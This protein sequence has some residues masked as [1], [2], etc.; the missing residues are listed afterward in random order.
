MEITILVYKARMD[1]GK[2]AYVV[3]NKN[4]SGKCPLLFTEHRK[5]V[6]SQIIRMKKEE[7]GTDIF[8]IFRPPHDAE[9]FGSAIARVYPLGYEEKFELI[10]KMKE[11]LKKS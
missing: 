6:A 3:R 2:K 4:S 9:T 11:E 7:G 1:D 5:Q 8:L 10:E